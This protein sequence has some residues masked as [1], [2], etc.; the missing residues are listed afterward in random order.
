MAELYSSVFVCVFV[1]VCVCVWREKESE[2]DRE[3]HHIF[4][5]HSLMDEHLASVSWLCE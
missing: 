3:I 1:C 4:F 2:R 5:I